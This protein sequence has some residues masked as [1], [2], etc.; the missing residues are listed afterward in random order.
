MTAPPPWIHPELPARFLLIVEGLCRAAAAR[1][2]VRGAN[3]S[4]TGRL[5]LVLWSRLRRVAERFAALAARRGFP[6]RLAS[7][8]PLAGQPARGQRRHLPH[9]FG[10][11]VRLVPKLR[12]IDCNEGPERKPKILDCAKG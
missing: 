7:R 5:M 6:R 10:W 2:G 8:A 4:I 11:L 12:S 9:R 3:R 1:L